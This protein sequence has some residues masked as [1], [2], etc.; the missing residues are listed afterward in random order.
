M[1]LAIIITF[2]GM[3]MKIIASILRHN[4]KVDLTLSLKYPPPREAINSSTNGVWASELIAAANGTISM[5]ISKA[6]R[7]NS[8][9]GMLENILL[10]TREVKGFPLLC[11]IKLKK[12]RMCRPP[13]I[14]KMRIVA[15]SPGELEEYLTTGVTNK[16]APGMLKIRKTPSIHGHFCSGQVFK[17]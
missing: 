13:S 1:T 6:M 3:K 7:P 9:K 11:T 5:T 2:M 14:E 10:Q 15:L 4:S 12:L 8:L 16:K 17:K